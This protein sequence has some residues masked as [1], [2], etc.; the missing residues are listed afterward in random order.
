[1]AF[2]SFLKRKAFKLKATASKS[3]QNHHKLKKKTSNFELALHPSKAPRRSTLSVLQAMD[4]DFL[5][6]ASAES[7]MVFCWYFV[8]LWLM[9][10]SC[11][12]SHLSTPLSKRTRTIRMV[13]KS[14]TLVNDWS[15]SG[16]AHGSSTIPSL[17][18]SAPSKK[19]RRSSCPNN[20][21][22][23]AACNW[24][25]TMIYIQISKTERTD[26]QTRA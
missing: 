13:G 17:V 6:E 25:K 5:Q 4:L 1:M 2:R 12:F 23:K 3:S 11:Y 10:L 16:A 7:W 14:E 24:V 26:R 15:S 8:G 22:G 20:T 18:W 19:L 9:I 21:V